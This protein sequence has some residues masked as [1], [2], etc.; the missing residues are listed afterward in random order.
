MEEFSPDDVAFSL[1]NVNEAH[2]DSIANSSSVFVA[3]ADKRPDVH[4]PGVDHPQAERTAMEF[5]ITSGITGPQVSRG[6]T[7][8]SRTVL[9]GSR[10]HPFSETPGRHEL[11]KKLAGSKQK[12][13]LRS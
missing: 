2:E 13:R 8:L 7:Q 10:V 6:F 1:L 4:T 11:V 5:L 12:A 9:T 3:V